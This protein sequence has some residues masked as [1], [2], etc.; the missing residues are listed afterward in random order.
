RLR[1]RDHGVVR[2]RPHHAQY[3]GRRDPTGASLADTV[4]LG[5]TNWIVRDSFGRIRLLAVARSGGRREWRIGSASTGR[6]TA[7]WSLSPRRG[8]RFHAAA[9]GIDRSLSPRR[10][11][12]A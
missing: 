8:A 2:L 10:N 12:A 1:R 3:G 6:S 5:R 9:R 4:D 11:G 7:L